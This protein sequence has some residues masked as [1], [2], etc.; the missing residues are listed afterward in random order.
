M[1]TLHVAVVGF[2]YHLSKIALREIAEADSTKN[3]KVTDKYIEKTDGTIYRVFSNPDRVRG[4]MI[5][6]L[7]VVDDFHWDIYNEQ[8]ELIKQIRFAMCR[9]CVPDQLQVQRYE[10][11]ITPVEERR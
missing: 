10:Y 8:R 7:I 3:K 5:D 11:P 6:Q 2:N 9:S 1:D 4:Y